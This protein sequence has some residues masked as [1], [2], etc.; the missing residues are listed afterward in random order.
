M[1]VKRSMFWFVLLALV[2]EG[3]YEA[4]EELKQVVKVATDT[5]ECRVERAFQAMATTTL[6]P[7]P[8]DEPVPVHSFQG[9]AESTVRAAGLVLA[10]WV[11][12]SIGFISLLSLVCCIQFSCS[13]SYWQQCLFSNLNNR[14]MAL[15]TL[16]Y[17][18]NIV[19]NVELY[20]RIL[21]LSLCEATARGRRKW[22]NLV[23][24]QRFVQ[25]R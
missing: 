12:L 24:S 9:H 3:V 6:L 7:L 1:I 2:L 10:G 11:Y 18:F 20:S 13:Y 19:R 4:L 5:L 16:N 25:V 21:T 22:H 15:L 23:Q 14:A 8:V 17:C